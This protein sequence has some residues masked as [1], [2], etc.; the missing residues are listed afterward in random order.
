MQMCRNC[1]PQ[2]V[3]SLSV[4]GG[5]KNTLVKLSAGPMSE[6]RR[7]APDIRAVGL[8][9][10]VKYYIECVSCFVVRDIFCFVVGA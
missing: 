1:I 2:C 8:E 4:A 3:I 10:R 9:S 6:T 7:S 5:V